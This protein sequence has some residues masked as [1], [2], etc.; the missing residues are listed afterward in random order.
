MERLQTE[1]ALRNSEELFQKTAE[2]VGEVFWCRDVI[3][4]RMLYVSA[5]YEKIWEKYCE[6]LYRQP[7]S[8]LD[9]V[10]PDDRTRV[11]AFLKGRGT[12]SELKRSIASFSQTVRFVG[13]VIGRFSFVIIAVRWIASP[14]FLRIQLPQAVG[15]TIPAIA[16]TGGAWI[17]VRGIGPRFQQSPDR[18]HGKCQPRYFRNT[19]RNA[20]P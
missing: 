9:F 1:E 17:S 16:K 20:G 5:A 8:F 13:F 19:A 2:E 6:S 15:G 10:H 11:R 3:R 18:H 14:E 4:N 7:D 12:V